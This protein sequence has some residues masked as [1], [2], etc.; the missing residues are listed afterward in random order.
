MGPLV[1]FG[2]ITPWT[3]VVLGFFSGVF[4][5]ATIES[6]GLGNAANIAAVFYLRDFKVPKVMFTAIVTALLGVYYFDVLGIMDMGRLEFSATLL[7]PFLIG[8]I[9]FGFGMVTSGLCPG[10]SLVAAATGKIDGFMVIGGIFI[11]AFLYDVVFTVLSNHFPGNIYTYLYSGN[12]GFKTL[13]EL[14]GL[15]PGVVILA[16][17][18]FALGFFWFGEFIEERNK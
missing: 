14:M 16:I 15:K 10:T 12:L 17:V 11:G 13:P 5:G 3:T 9:V 18:L 4:F 7:W 2:I 1:D 8:G 6:S